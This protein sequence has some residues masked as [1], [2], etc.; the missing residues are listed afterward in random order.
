M[1][2]LCGIASKEETGTSKRSAI[3]VLK[4][5]LGNFDPFFPGIY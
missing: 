1:I 3:I 5:G 2:W 4:T